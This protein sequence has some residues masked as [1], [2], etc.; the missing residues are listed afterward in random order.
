[1]AQKDYY[2][3]LGLGK[4][5]SPDE[6][7]KAYRKLAMKYHPDHSKGN[8]AAE[9]KFKEISEAYAVLSD[10]EKRK[11]YDTYGSESFQQNF[12]QE[13]IFR[14]SNIEDI[15]KEFGFGGGAFFSSGRKTGG[16]GRR[17]SFNPESMFNFNGGRQQQSAPV[18]GSDVEYEIPLTLTEI[19]TGTS[20]T[21]SL[22]NPDGGA[23]TLTVKIPKG[24]ISGKK[25]RFAG[26][27]QPSPYG[28]PAG[29]LFIKSKIVDD[30]VF[31]HKEFDL[32]LSREI[33]LTE[34]LLGT[35]ISVPT[36]DGK[37]LNL[38][39]P[40]GT[41]HKSKM[42]LAGNGI[43]HMKGDG[44]GDLYV[45]IQVAAPGNLTKQQK[46]LIESLAGTGI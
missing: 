37:Q 5:A 1:M 4:T 44:A 31:R 33:K 45:E 3:S 7:K 32:Y 38:K 43:P 24:M 16:G 25:L 11:Q 8:K 46:Q 29:D 12:S 9:D 42:R 17:F 34:A 27:G 26:R 23:E 35:Q 36:L 2:K 15:L 40:P 18:K 30:P 14:G 39:I 21:L 22:Q 28:G 19:S 10:T 41:K 13:D 6:I 20:R